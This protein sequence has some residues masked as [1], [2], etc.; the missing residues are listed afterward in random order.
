MNNLE[1]IIAVFQ[2]AFENC[3]PIDAESSKDTVE[4]WDSFGHLILILELEK[5]FDIKL[6]AAQIESIK[7]VKDILN[8]L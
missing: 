4:P 2:R 8:L 6:S 5:E 3:P 7:S 1:R